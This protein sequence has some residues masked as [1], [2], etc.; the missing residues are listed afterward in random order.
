MQLVHRTN[1]LTR[2]LN[3]QKIGFIGVV[4]GIVIETTTKLGQLIIRIKATSK[5]QQQ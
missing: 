2:Y 4:I 5:Q 3:S 1:K